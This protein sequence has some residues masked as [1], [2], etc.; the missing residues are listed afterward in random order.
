M[1]HERMPIRLPRTETPPVLRTDFSDVAGWDRLVE[2]LKTPVGFEKGSR[3]V[4]DY[5][6]ATSFVTLVDDEKYRD[7]T[8]EEVQEVAASSRGGDFLYDHVYLADAETL[9]SGDLLLLGIDIDTSVQ[10]EDDI[11]NEVPFRVPAVHI[12]NVE[13]NDELGNLSF[14]ESYEMDWVNLEVYVAGPG[15][16]VYEKFRELGQGRGMEP[17][18]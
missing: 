1:N 7:L 14:R 4:S 17:D 9:A 11:E 18:G 3:D 8:P 15:T 2:A 13:I 10:D 5:D 6:L 12:T 16:I